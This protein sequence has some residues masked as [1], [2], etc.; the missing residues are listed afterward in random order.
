MKTH[1]FFVCIL[2]L[3]GLI[4]SS[5]AQAPEIQLK[6]Q[7]IIV[8]EQVYGYLVKDGAGW[9]KNFSFQSRRD[10]ELAYAKVITKV[11]ANGHHYDYYEISFKGYQQ[12][13]EMDIEVDFDKRLAF[14]L[15][16]YNIVKNDLLNRESVEKF[17]ARYPPVISKRLNGN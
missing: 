2:L 7:K 5:K 10:E 8:D 9:L 6:G 11:M 3:F 17:L 13:A 4:L 1:K 15:V 16:L 14:D 12:K